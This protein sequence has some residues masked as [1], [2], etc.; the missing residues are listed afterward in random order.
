MG[1]T[2]YGSVGTRVLLENER[3]RVWEIELQPGETLAMHHHDLGLVDR[4]RTRPVG[5]ALLLLKSDGVLAQPPASARSVI[6][7][8]FCNTPRR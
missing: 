3:V 6:P 7:Q 1:T 2:Q 4:A 5:D 8:R